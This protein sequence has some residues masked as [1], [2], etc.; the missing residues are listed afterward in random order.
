MCSHHRLHSSVTRDVVVV[1]HT[2]FQVKVAL[3]VV[4]QV[5]VV[6]HNHV[7]QCRWKWTQYEGAC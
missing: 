7:T 3:R 5:T 1:C 2:Q 4:K 6:L